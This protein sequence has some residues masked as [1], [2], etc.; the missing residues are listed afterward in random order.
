MVKCKAGHPHWTQWGVAECNDG[1]TGWWGCSLADRLGD[2]P[3]VPRYEEPWPHWFH[4]SKSAA[5]ECDR[6]RELKATV[7]KEGGVNKMRWRY[8]ALQMIH[9]ALEKI[10]R[11]ECLLI[12]NG[13]PDGLHCFACTFESI[14]NVVIRAME[15][16]SKDDQW[17][18]AIS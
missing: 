11:C 2:S 13:N 17:K 14:K 12:G 7:A 5:D 15:F 6:A 16:W 1:R 3:P 4:E 9:A 8:V 18:K 10:P